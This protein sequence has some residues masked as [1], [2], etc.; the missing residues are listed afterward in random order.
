MKKNFREEN[1]PT[2]LGTP[3][4]VLNAVI[5]SVSNLNQERLFALGLR[6][7]IKRA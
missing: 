5:G 3:G 2:A 1:K 6:A 7:V 4:A